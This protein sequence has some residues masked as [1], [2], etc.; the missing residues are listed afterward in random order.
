M[1]NAEW[2]RAELGP[3]PAR[4]LAITNEQNENWC[5]RQL[6]HRHSHLRVALAEAAFVHNWP[7][8]DEKLRATSQFTMSSSTI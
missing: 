4:A 6:R 3:N 8:R 7:D 1:S 2:P 5:R